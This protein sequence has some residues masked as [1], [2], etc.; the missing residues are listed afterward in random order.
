MAGALNTVRQSLATCTDSDSDS[1]PQPMDH[2]Y[3]VKPVNMI[4][5]STDTTCVL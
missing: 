4:S 5:H 1:V 2:N 3:N